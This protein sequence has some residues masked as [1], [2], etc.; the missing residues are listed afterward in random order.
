MLSRQ[1]GPAAP[2]ADTHRARLKMPATGCFVPCKRSR[3]FCELSLRT[4]PHTKVS[5]RQSELKISVRRD[6]DRRELARCNEQDR[7]QH[8][9]QRSF[10]YADQRIQKRG[11]YLRRES[12]LL[13]HRDG[14]YFDGRP[15]LSRH[16]GRWTF[17]LPNRQMATTEVLDIIHAQPHTN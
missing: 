12:L 8:R 7:R 9:A 15:P 17:S 14:R 4:R 6:C 5:Q 1:R 3:W 2:R 10:W 13:S 16:C 11:K